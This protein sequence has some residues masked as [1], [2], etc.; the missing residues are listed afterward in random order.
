MSGRE[1]ILKLA[2]LY[3]EALRLKRT[4]V[5]WR[6]FQDTNKLDVIEGGRDLLLGRYERAM[7]FFSDH[8]PDSVAWPEG[9]LR[10]PRSPAPASL[11]EQSGAAA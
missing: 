10:P 4:T 1:N 3:G 7:Q 5:S 6:L 2:S 11:P 8:W 9:I